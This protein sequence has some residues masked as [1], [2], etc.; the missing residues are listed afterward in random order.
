MTIVHPEQSARRHD[1]DLSFSNI[2][3]YLIFAV[4]VGSAALFFSDGF[5][6][7]ADAWTLPEYSHGPL[8]PVLSSLLFLRHAREVPLVSGA[9]KDR[10]PGYAILL[11]A[12]MLALMGKIARIG[13]VVAYAMIMFVAGVVIVSFG[14]RRG[15]AFWP[16]VLHLVFMLP[17]PGILYWKISTNLQILSSE[18]GVYFIQLAGVPV[19]LAGNIIDLGVYKLH[20]AEAC[21]GLR[22]LY[23]VMSFSYIFA[24]LYQGPI[25]IKAIL[26]LS[27]APITVLMNS[28]RIGIVG[29]IVDSY[30][31]A[32]VDGITHLLEGWV[33]FL[34]SIVLLFAL[35]RVLMLLRGDRGS[36]SEALDLEFDGL[37]GQIARIR[38][39]RASPALIASAVTTTLALGAWTFAPDR[40]EAVIERE[41]LALF[42][43]R[44]G[45]WRSLG[46][47]SLE[48]DI[49]EALGADDYFSALY[50][51]AE[52]GVQ[53]DLF[54]AWYRDQTAGGIHSPE[55]C[56]PSGG[57]EMAE[58]MAVDISDDLGVSEP[59]PV[60]RAVI[61]RGE[62]RLL[63][64]YWFEQYGG[65]VASDYRAKAAL[66]RDSLI[67]GRSDGALVRAITP[68]RRGE[69][70]AAA[71]ARLIDMLK[72]ALVELPRFVPKR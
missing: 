2:T 59:F 43:A 24:T 60:N 70:R 22:Y 13:D 67:Y 58:I 44:L 61:Q 72:P 29:I 20:V 63:V 31:L 57:Y 1:A 8:I 62:S 40:A 25:W 11:A 33:I 27:A 45:E 65:R 4:L 64:Y 15:R 6:V 9:V 12:L 39:V 28:V 66:L 36:L 16:A 46:L 48:R 34:C 69:E 10:W 3:G 38:L 30:G 56:L 17:L 42:P 37:G 18:L 49:E 71:E 51:H 14:W 19:F 52:T 53:N 47:Q 32:H 23:P 35:V 26:L 50:L 21:S 5:I 7:L 54:I 41:P 55:V 68:L